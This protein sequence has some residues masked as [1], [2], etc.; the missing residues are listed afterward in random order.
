MADYE[1]VDLWLT[2]LT[3]AISVF[4]AFLSATSA[5]LV[6]AHFKKGGLQ[7]PVYW[8]ALSLYSVAVLFFVILF[9]KTSE[10]AI[11]VRGQMHESDLHWFNAV[12]EPQFIA[13]LV[14]GLG[15]VVQIALAAG[16]LWYFRS[17][18]VQKR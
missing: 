16:S 6:V 5:L 2:H 1:L 18:R 12:Y 8:L 3:L 13:P 7:K 4:V 14:L 10:G 11:N 17:T 15:I 9:A